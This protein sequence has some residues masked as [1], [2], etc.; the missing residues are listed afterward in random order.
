M[1]SIANKYLKTVTES[2]KKKKDGSWDCKVA[3]YSCT[4]KAVRLVRMKSGEKMIEM[5]VWFMREI[6]SRFL[7]LS[8]FL[9][10]FKTFANNQ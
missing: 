10:F 1:S 5:T 2:C 9:F 7:F 6:G 8:F 4:L 3:I